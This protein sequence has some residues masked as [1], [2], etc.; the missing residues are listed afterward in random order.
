MKMMWARRSCSGGSRSS[1]RGSRCAVREGRFAVDKDDVD[2]LLQAQEL[3]AVIEQQR[4]A[5][6]FADR[7]QAAFHPVLV[8][9]HEHV[10]QVRREHERLVAG[11]L[12]VEQKRA[13]VGN[14]AR[15]MALIERAEAVE[16]LLG[17]RRT[18]ALL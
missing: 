2:P 5:T 4:V 17:E 11:H 1:P 8:D 16:Q 12:G 14:N 9:Q 7:V 13:P 18:G 6:E 10:L 3:Q 15:R